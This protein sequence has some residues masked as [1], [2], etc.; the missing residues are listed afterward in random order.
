MLVYFCLKGVYI[1]FYS[2]GNVFILLFLE[3]LDNRNNFL[4]GVFYCKYKVYK[5]IVENVFKFFFKSK[6]LFIF[7]YFLFRMF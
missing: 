7:S 5:N 1:G 6:S 2:G 4:F 3:L